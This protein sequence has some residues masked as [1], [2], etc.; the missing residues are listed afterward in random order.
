MVQI[1]GVPACLKAQFLE[2]QSQHL[3]SS[4][5]GASHAGMNQMNHFD[6]GI[7]TRKG[8][9][10]T[11]QRYS[12]RGRLPPQGGST[13]YLLPKI[14]MDMEKNNLTNRKGNVERKIL[15]CS[16]FDDVSSEC[17]LL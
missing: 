13:H 16:T 3:E 8:L 10:K 12:E 9:G 5:D 7:Q 2:K 15:V 1:G 6:W 17:G 4:G 14:T 11:H